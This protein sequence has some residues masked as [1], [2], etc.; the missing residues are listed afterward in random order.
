LC[1]GEKEVAEFLIIV[2]RRLKFLPGL[3]VGVLFGLL[4][5]APLNRQASEPSDPKPHQATFDIAR[6]SPTELESLTLDA[7]T[8]LQQRKGPV[9]HRGFF[10]LAWSSWDRPGNNLSQVRLGMENAR[11]LLPLAKKLTLESLDEKLK[12]SRLS[13]EKRLIAAVHRL[14]LDPSLGGSSEV[15]DDDLKVIYVGPDYAAFLTSDDETMLLLGH[16]LTH[17]AARAGRL[18]FFIEDVN[19]VA[20]AAA[21]LELAERQ[22]EELACDYTGAEVL[23]RYIA[24][25]PTEETSVERFSRVFDYEPPAERLARA[26]EDFCASYNGDSPDDEHL[27]QDQTIRALLGLDPELKALIPG[28]AI[29]TRL[30]R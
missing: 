24:L 7:L 26:W 3:A 10:N 17:V 30:C 21:N 20:R 19:K 6:L 14:V 27:S 5:T 29:S 1:R 11:R 4:A 18:N 25:H 8:A 9:A 12:T 22:K 28:D 15:R 16:E 2:S 13:R 23:K